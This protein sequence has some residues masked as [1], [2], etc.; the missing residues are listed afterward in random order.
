MLSVISGAVGVSLVSAI[1]LALPVLQSGAFGVVCAPD[2]KC[3][4]F[5]WFPGV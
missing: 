2:I 4:G 1:G 5:D 3:G